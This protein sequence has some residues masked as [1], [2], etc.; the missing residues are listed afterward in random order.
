MKP[1]YIAAIIASGALSFLALNATGMVQS[2]QSLRTFSVST[3]Y[4]IA[5]TQKDV[6]LTGTQ[7]KIPFCNKYLSGYTETNGA[8]VIVLQQASWEY[9]GISYPLY[10]GGQRSV[11]L[12][13]GDVDICCDWFTCPVVAG[14]NGNLRIKWSAASGW[15]SGEQSDGT[16]VSYQYDPANDINQVDNTGAL[17]APTGATSAGYPFSSTGIIVMASATSRSLIGVGSSLFAGTGDYAP[18]AVAKTNGNGAGGFMRRA[19][20]QAALPL[21]LHAVPG[22][23][24]SNETSGSGALLASLAKY[25]NMAVTELSSND[26]AAGRTVAQLQADLQTIWTRLKAAMPAGSRIFHTKILPRCTTTDRGVTL[27]GQTPLAAFVAGGSRDVMNAW[28]DTQVGV[29][30]TG[31]IDIDTPCRDSVQTDR[32]ASEAFASTL[33]SAVT[34]V[35]TTGISITDSPAAFATLVADPGGANLSSG[36]AIVTSQTGTGPFTI[37]IANAFGVA[38]NAGANVKSTP[39]LDTTH[40]TATTCANKC[41]PPVL[42]AIT[43]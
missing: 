32:W 5:R 34:S 15:V 24:A 23:S 13:P 40:P 22:R 37:V 33:P 30:L 31:V 6:R 12:N 28:F 14:T 35:Q 29:N 17:T 38:Q 9:A 10:F 26:L 27:A 11:T 19:A 41:V 16:S 43:S 20:Y 3:N 2:P 25:A 7:V 39:S 21:A 42:T 1:N 8:G 4:G 18:N 36:Y